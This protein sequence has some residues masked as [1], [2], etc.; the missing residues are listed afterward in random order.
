[1]QLVIGA[2]QGH[3][4]MNRSALLKLG[5]PETGIETFGQANKSTNDEAA[6]L[7]DWVERHGA[8]RIIVPTEAGR[9]VRWVFSRA[10]AGMG[11]Y[12]G[13]VL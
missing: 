4:E 3:T 10:F 13:V 11:T 1:M 9:R 8:L 6:A 5:V 12:L 7:R 2:V